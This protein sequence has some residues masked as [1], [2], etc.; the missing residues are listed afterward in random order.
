MAVDAARG[1][2]LLGMIAVHVLKTSDNAA[3]STWSYAFFGGRASAAFAML[4]GV[5]IAFM[6]GRRQVPRSAGR[7]T[8]ATLGARALFIGALGLALGYTDP[9]LGA[10][11]LPYYA[12]MFALAIPLVFLPTR[13]LVTTGLTMAATTPTLV[14]LL[15]PDLSGPSHE[16]LSFGHLRDPVALLTELSITG[17]YPALPW[18]AYLCAGLVIGR[19]DLSRPRVGAAL[20]GVGIAVTVA[21][22]AVSSLLLDHAGLARIQAAQP[23]SELTRAET[24][25]L[26]K[27]G[28]KG[29]TPTSTWWWLAVDAPHTSTPFNLL[30]ATGTAMALLGVMLLAGG[31]KSALRRIVVAVQ[32]PL[33]AAGGMTLTLYTAHIVF[34]NSGYDVFPAD[35]SYLLQAV[36]ALL[37]GTIW[38]AAGVRGPLEAAAA[39]LARQA[40]RW[41]SG[42]EG[43]SRR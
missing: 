10:V 33:A 26:L 12:M 38:R 36:A 2:A 1:V 30:S 32:T 20:L 37:V 24:M 18:L 25:E 31:G 43:R 13:A 16:N 5:A 27:F 8:A 39:A 4:T 15:P 6:T 19:L 21:A 41:A 22:S 35:A 29:T 17:F 11:I 14:H 34:I 28:G 9:Q 42:A 7:T 23:D 40:R 3:L